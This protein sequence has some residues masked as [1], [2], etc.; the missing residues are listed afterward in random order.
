MAAVI[1]SEALKDTG[2]AETLGNDGS[3]RSFMRDVHGRLQTVDLQVA[4]RGL[5]GGDR[6]DRW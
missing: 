4:E 5:V 1:N 3:D 6:I 2:A